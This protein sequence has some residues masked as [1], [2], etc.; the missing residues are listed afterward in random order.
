MADENYDIDAL[1]DHGH[2]KQ[3]MRISRNATVQFCSIFIRMKK[4][5]TKKSGSILRQIG[6][7]ISFK[8]LKCGLMMLSW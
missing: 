7:R 1:V 6:C 5:R 4:V 2:L 3:L 8:E